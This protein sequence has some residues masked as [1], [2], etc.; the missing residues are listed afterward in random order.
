[1]IQVVPS[2]SGMP[3]LALGGYV[4]GLAARDLGPMSEVSLRRPVPLGT[5]L[6]VERSDDGC[7][8]RAGDAILAKGRRR[9]MP[10]EPPPAVS[11]GE[12]EEASQLYPGFRAHLFPNCY[13][14]GPA[15][16]HGEGLRVFTGPVRGTNMVACAWIP[17]PSV[18]ARD[19]TV[20]IEILWAAIDCPGIWALMVG[21]P[22]D[23]PDRAVT[24]TIAVDVRGSVRAG[25]RYVIVGWPLG[26]DGRKLFAGAAICSAEGVPL[27]VARQTMILTP[28]GVPLGAESWTSADNPELLERKS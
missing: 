8:L 13:C 16:P 22:P 26:R 7:V 5:E 20:R 11:L 9:D 28:H 2:F 24:G 27:V 1:M 12:A 6:T 18:A 19:G 14:C 17:T 10:L 3:G 25:E 21:S 4:C 15:R 23:S